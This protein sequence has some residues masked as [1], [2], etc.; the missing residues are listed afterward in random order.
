MVGDIAGEEHRRLEQ[1]QQAFFQRRDGHAVDAVQVQH[2]VGVVAHL[3]HRAVDGEA[4]LVGLVAR[5][6]Q[7][8]AVEV[9]LQQAGGGDLVECQAERVDQ[10]LV[11]APRHAHGDVVGDQ[12]APAEQLDQSIGGGQV[13]TRLPFQGI[14]VFSHCMA[15]RRRCSCSH[16]V[17]TQRITCCAGKP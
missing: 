8:V 17:P 10:E 1:W 2:A 4:G 15:P 12:V 13:D 14:Q 5:L 9:D 16:S 7:L 6:A 11:V 3:V